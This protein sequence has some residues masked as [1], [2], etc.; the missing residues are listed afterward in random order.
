LRQA[1]R[2]RNIRKAG[3]KRLSL[4]RKSITNK[5]RRYRQTNKKR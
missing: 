1:K 5:K 2:K 4:L 3:Y